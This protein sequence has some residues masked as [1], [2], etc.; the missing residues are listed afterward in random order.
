MVIGFAYT[1]ASATA[2]PGGFGIG[3]LG[4][5]GGALPSI[6]NVDTPLPDLAVAPA[7]V[8]E[9]TG[10]KP[11]GRAEA[12]VDKFPTAVAVTP[13]G[14]ATRLSLWVFCAVAWAFLTHLGLTRLRRT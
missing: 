9:P 8:T 4:G 11:R 3:D 14:S 1:A 6:G 12:I 7:P 10:S 5:S 13:L 2:D